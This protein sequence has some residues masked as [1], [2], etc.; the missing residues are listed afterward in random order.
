MKKTFFAIVAAM[1]LVSC[2]EQAKV[3]QLGLTEEQFG[4]AEYDGQQVKLYTIKNANGMVA[5]LTNQGAKLVSL[6]APDK[7]GKMED[8]V[9]GYPTAADYAKCDQRAGV[10]EPFFGATIG[11]YGNRLAGGMFVIDGDTTKVEINEMPGKSLHGGSKGYH[12]QMWTVKEQTENKVVFT[13]HDADGTM[14]YKGNVDVELTYEMCD[15]NGLKL[16]YS[17]TTDAPTAINLTHHSFFNLDGEGAETV[18]DHVLMIPAKEITAVNRF[19]IP[20]GELMPV[21]GTAFDFNTPHAISDS[22]ASDHLQMKIGGGYDHNWVLSS[23]PNEDGLRVA[24]EVKSLKSGRIMTVIT[25]EPGVQFYGGNFLNNTQVGKSGKTYPRRS[26]LCL[27]TQHFPDSP[28]HENFP[29]TILRPG[30]TYSHV[31]VYK[32]DVEK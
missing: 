20:T 29:S 24:A 26:A 31:C 27:E 5:Q 9:L 3:P 28:N 23:E 17:A 18:N 30:E 10:G 7:E 16:T 4:T 32:F 19:L 8:V 14:G 15:C 13:L 11:R 1:A 12:S 6:Y 21:E 25:T 22:I 2:A